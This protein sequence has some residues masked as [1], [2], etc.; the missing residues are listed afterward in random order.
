MGRRYHLGED[1][2]KIDLKE[3]AC[4][5]LDWFIWL[6]AGRDQWQVLVN[7]VKDLWIL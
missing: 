6:R 4:E 1:T 7:M 2:I 3:A 5:N